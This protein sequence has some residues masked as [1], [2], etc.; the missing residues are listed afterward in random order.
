MRWGF[1]QPSELS[2]LVTAYEEFTDN[3]KD[4]YETTVNDPGLVYTEKDLWRNVL[5]SDK[6]KLNS[7]GA[8]T[9][10][11]LTANSFS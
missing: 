6:F 9:S 7:T 1:I 5:T 2:A 4:Y 8:V 10:L 3:L 11:S